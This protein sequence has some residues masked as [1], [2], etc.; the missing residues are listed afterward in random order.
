MVAIFMYEDAAEETEFLFI[1]FLNIKDIY[2]FAWAIDSS[3]KM[4][5]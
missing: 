4:N 1:P 5:S 3:K 2:S